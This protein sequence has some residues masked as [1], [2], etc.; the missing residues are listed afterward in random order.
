MTDKLI[1]EMS[2]KEF[3]AV[4]DAY[5]ERETQDMGELPAPLFYEALHN[6]FSSDKAK[7]TESLLGLES[8]I[9]GNRWVLSAPPG[10]SVPP[11]IREVE[12]NLPGVRVVVSREPVAA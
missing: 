3:D 1:S 10:V 9:V 6:I 12:I 2:P 5:I 4:I 11:D 8:T 7:Q